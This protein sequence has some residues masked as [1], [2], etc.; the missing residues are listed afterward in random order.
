M[1]GFLT[2]IVLTGLA[3][4]LFACTGE[5]PLLTDGPVMSI[6]AIAEAGAAP[7]SLLR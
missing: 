7:A 2:A 4:I 5:A 3:G 6:N 1:R